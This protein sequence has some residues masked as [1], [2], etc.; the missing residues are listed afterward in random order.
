M[1]NDLLIR[2]LKRKESLFLSD[3]KVNDNKIQESIK[4]TRI[5]VIGAAGS[6][7]HAFV[8]Q[9]LNYSLKSLHLV[10]ISENNLVEVV[11]DIR[12]SLIRVPDDFKTFAVD[13]GSLEFNKLLSSEKNYDYIINFAAIK[14]VRSEKDP[15]SLMRM[16][17]TN[18]SYVKDLLEYLK[19]IPIKKHFSVSSD[20]ATNPA[21]IMGATKIFM[22]RILLSYSDKISFSTARFA[23]VAFSDGSL[24]YGFLKRLEKKQPLAA[25]NDVKRYFIS[26]KEASHLCI[27]SCFLGD[28]RDIF[29]PKLDEKNDLITF[30]DI[31]SAVLESRGLTP[32]LCFSEEEAKQKAFRLNSNSKTWPCYFF[33]SDTTG[34]K[35]F[36]EFYTSDDNVD[37]NKYTNVGVI[38]Q[39]PFNG[40][41]KIN[42]AIKI[43]EKIKKANDWR[44]EDMIKAIEFAVPELCHEEKDK[45][46][47]QKM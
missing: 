44:K 37:F 12:S 25:P 17:N 42:K 26:H 10:D 31:A 35:P 30:S 34:E 5:L 6:I 39:P 45:N 46:L 41:S 1:E 23:N 7:G 36:E 4:G 24:L 43:I 18:V 13:F 27:L 47:D 9:L 2:I 29:F 11:R 19:R 3:I 20:K 33:T 38:K 16:Y 22:E 28:N 8:K 15:Y 14:H 40:Y 21:S 32:E